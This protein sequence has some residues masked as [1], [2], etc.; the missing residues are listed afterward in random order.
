MDNDNILD[1][2]EVMDEA[3][4]IRCKFRPRDGS[5]WV[6]DGRYIV[7]RENGQRHIEITYRDGIVH[8]PYLDFWSNE[9]VACEGQ[10][11]EGKQEGIW[12]FY[13]KDGT[14]QA[15]ILFKEGNQIES[16]QYIFDEDGKLRDIVC[17]NDFKNLE[18]KRVP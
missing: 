11:H 1:I 3:Q 5:N 10:H 9:K 6:P 12:H 14:M 16:T 7:L 18:R 17:S 15:L 13:N 4:K 8:G 2:T